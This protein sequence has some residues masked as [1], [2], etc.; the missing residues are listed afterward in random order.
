M[1]RTSSPS[2]R[3]RRQAR[4]I[5]STLQRIRRRK[6]DVKDGEKKS[7]LRMNTP[8]TEAS[9]RAIPLPTFAVEALARHRDGQAAEREFAGDRWTETGLVFTSTIGTPLEPRNVLRQFQSLLDVVEIPRRRF[10]DLRHTAA[11]LLLA[12]GAT[13]H[14]VKEILG[15]SQIA[16]T[17]NLYGHGYVE[18]MRSAVDRVGSLLAP[19]EAAPNPVAPLLAP[20]GASKHPS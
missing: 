2:E 18:V 1:P 8:K 17:A 15:H 6:S 12:Q 19:Q 14:E 20:L 11:S 16:I 13:L 5:S 7:R 10:H 9:A 3:K 4:T